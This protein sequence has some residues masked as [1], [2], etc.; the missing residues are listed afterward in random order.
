MSVKKS[1]TL[2]PDVFHTAGIAVFSKMQRSCHT[3]FIVESSLARTCQRSRLKRAGNSGIAGLPVWRS[4]G[5][6]LQLL[7]GWVQ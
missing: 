7:G 4:Y 3:L 5:A 6:N 1:V 2:E